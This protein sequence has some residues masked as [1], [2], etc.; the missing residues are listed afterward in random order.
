MP[1][2]RLAAKIF[3]AA[4]QEIEKDRARHDRHL[5]V[6]HREAAAALAEKGHNSAHRI[7][8]INGAAR[9]D[10]GI[11]PLDGHPRFEQGRVAQPRR[12]AVNGD[13]GDGGS[14]ENQRGDAGAEVARHAHGQREGRGRR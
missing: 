10:Q 8:A 14:I 2:D 1:I 6:A 3:V 9:K 12:A 13:R 5:D 7:E 4:I 11:D